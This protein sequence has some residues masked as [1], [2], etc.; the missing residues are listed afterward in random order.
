[1]FGKHGIPDV[2]GKT[3]LVV[4][5]LLIVLLAAGGSELGNGS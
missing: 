5:T 1:M 4:L 3:C 2:R